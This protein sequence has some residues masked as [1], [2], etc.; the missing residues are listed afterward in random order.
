[1]DI[2]VSGVV[3]DGEAE[4]G[5]GG[6]DVEE[7]DGAAAHHGVHPQPDLGGSGLALR[8]GLEEVVEDGGLLL[9]VDVDVHARLQ[10]HLQ[11]GL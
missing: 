3:R 5:G 10:R 2:P 9:V 6:A 1:M 7:G 11:V 8:V 4:L